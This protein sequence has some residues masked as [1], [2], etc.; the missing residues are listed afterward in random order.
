MLGKMSRIYYVYKSG[1]QGR[2][3]TI[4]INLEEIGILM[5]Y[6]ESLYLFV[7]STIE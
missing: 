6:I 7:D 5:G 2:G 4:H 3:H 1:A